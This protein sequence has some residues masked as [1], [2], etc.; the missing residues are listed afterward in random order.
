MNDESF[1]KI[2]IVVFLVFAFGGCGAAYVNSKDAVNVKVT[3][4]TVK[5]YGKDGDKFL[6]FTDKES[7]ENVDSMLF[8]KFGSA[9]VYG[10]IEK[11]K[12]YTFTVAGWRIPFFSSYRNV[13]AIKSRDCK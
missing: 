5:R 12:C 11:G 2:I 4:K 8:G 1:A 7:F 9:D 13:L 3:D 10:K 6:I